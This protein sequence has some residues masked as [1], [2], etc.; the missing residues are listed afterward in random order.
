[1]LNICNIICTKDRPKD[2]A[3]ILDS[4]R[5]QSR[6]SNKIIIVD[7]SDNPVK[8]VVDRYSDLDID[9]TTVRPPG[10][11]KQRN[12]GISM[13][14]EDTEWI[15]FLDDDLVLEDNSLE[16][17][18]IFLEKN[19][20]VM[21]CGLVINNQPTFSP[22]F[23]RSIFFTD[24]DPGGV[25]TKSGY[26]SAI[27][28]VK[29]DLEVEWLYGGATY[30]NRKI[31]N[32]FKF[33]E[34]FSGVGY[35]EDVDFSYRVSREMK[36]MLCSSARCIHN[37]RPR[38]KEILYKHA[39]WHFVSWWYFASKWSHINKLITLWSMF[40]IFL[41]NLGIGV[42][43]PSTYRIRAALGNL[44]ALKIIALGKARTFKG[45]QKT[46]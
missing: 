30:W 14:P 9:Y 16:N 27:R 43:K 42:F 44:N 15:G 8:H 4:L 35:L 1:M 26:A 19:N 25:I 11:T 24:R 36:L 39:T 20:D 5:S 7:G 41:S 37:Y 13:L 28:P 6:K 22:H 23:Y 29:E 21:G 46:T 31:I 2:L 12:V 33:D 10:L 32:T 3:A 40:G 34:W 45:Y 38:T 17:L 18:E